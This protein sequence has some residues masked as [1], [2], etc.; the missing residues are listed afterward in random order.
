MSKLSVFD[1]IA[2]QLIGFD[3]FVKGF[4][5]SESN[6]PPYN[7][8]KNSPTEYELQVALA[9]WS[10]DEFEVLYTTDYKLTVQSKNFNEVKDKDVR[11]KNVEYIH[12]GIAKRFFKLQFRCSDN[13]KIDEATFEDGIL[14]IIITSEKPN[15]TENKIQI[16]KK[17]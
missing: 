14:K 12:N 16:K 13:A 10:E 9:G 7:I 1:N 17:K 2:R 11:S 8:I 15:P 5:F 6:Y 4:T 3:E